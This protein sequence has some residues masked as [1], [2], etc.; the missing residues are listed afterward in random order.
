MTL[1]AIIASRPEVA[2]LVYDKYPVTNKERQCNTEKN[3]MDGLRWAYGKRL[4]QNNEH[5]SKVEYGR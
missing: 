3:R 4:M 2:K 5:V 1:T